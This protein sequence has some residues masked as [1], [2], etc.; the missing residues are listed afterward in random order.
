MTGL[1][2]DLWPKINATDSTYSR[3]RTYSC[4]KRR[5]TK[6]EAQTA[7]N[8]RMSSRHNRPEH[9]RMYECR[10][11]QAWHITHRRHFDDTES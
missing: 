6:V 3:G 11:C 7:I 4:S 10:R 9:L 5:Y 8:S 1:A 2:P